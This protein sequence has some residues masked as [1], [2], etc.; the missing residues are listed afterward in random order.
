MET[1]H[2]LAPKHLA[3]VPLAC[4]Y[5]MLR[6]V[7]TTSRI[8]ETTCE[9]CKAAIAAWK[10]PVGKVSREI[11]PHYSRMSAWSDDVIGTTPFTY[12][13][14]L[15]AAAVERLEAAVQRLHPSRAGWGCGGYSCTVLAVIDL[16]RYGQQGHGLVVTE[17][18]FGTGD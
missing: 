12:T 4:G 13:G 8:A 7:K 10:A 14:T 1:T 2:L 18:Y 5:P 9:G 6:S 15:D 11:E 3:R 17:Q 16:A